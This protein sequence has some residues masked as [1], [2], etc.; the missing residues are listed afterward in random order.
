MSECIELLT[1]SK[2]LNNVRK[3]I[4]NEKY[5]GK[6]QDK[7]RILDFR[8]S[9]IPWNSDLKNIKNKH[10]YLLM[11]NLLN[12]DRK[13]HLKLQGKAKLLA[14]SSELTNNER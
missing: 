13:L 1:T 5:D 11:S 8:K 14:K 4:N 12:Q 6:F 9:K 10:V 2:D 7:K 3:L